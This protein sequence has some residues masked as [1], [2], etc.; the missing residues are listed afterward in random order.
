MELSTG[1]RYQIIPYMYLYL[2][3]ECTMYTVHCTCTFIT[4]N[5]SDVHAGKVPGGSV[6]PAIVGS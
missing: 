6:L 2:Y 3:N 4:K 1:T 5:P